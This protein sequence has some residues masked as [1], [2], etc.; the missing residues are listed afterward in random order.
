MSVA[1]IAVTFVA[2]SAFFI[3]NARDIKTDV[4]ATFRLS[5]EP[6]KDSIDK[7][8]AKISMTEAKQNAL[9]LAVGVLLWQSNR[10]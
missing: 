5:I 1:G 2:V 10:R 8:D 9:I 4:S 7:L 6:L 3:Q